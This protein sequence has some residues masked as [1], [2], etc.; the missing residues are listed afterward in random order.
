[1]KF[2]E[3]IKA[4]GPVAFWVALMFFGSSDWMSADHTSRYLTPL[5]HWLNPDISP[6]TVARVHLLVRKAAHVTEYAILT[7]LLFRALRWSIENPWWRA[8]AALVPALVIAPLDE[9]HQSFIASRTGSPID[10]LIDYS[11][12]IVGLLISRLIYLALKRR[13]KV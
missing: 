3:I 5:L 6:A 1:M 12:A 8:A 2:T 13:E 4:W 11:G 7:A 9:F 10:V